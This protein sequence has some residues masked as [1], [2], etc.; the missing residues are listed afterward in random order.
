MKT[1]LVN[2]LEEDYTLYTDV[3][4]GRKAFRTKRNPW[5]QS[6]SEPFT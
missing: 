6:R 3:S 5:R 1:C 2:N 4:E